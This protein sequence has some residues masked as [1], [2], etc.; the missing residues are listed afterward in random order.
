MNITLDGYLAGP[1]CEL[2]WHFETWAPDMAE[3]LARE[4]SKTDTILLGRITYQA[5]AAY[6]Q[7]RATDLS[8]PREEIAFV[9]M[10]NAHHKIVYSKTL[11]QA[12]WNNSSILQGDLPSAIL[13]LKQS[14]PDK[15][16][17]IYGSSQLV[18][19]LIDLGLIDE[20]HLW[21][22][23]V[24]LGKGKP[25]FKAIRDKFVLRLS[26]SRTFN[27]GVVLLQYDHIGHSTII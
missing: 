13:Q 6:W 22:H 4:L 21:L 1:N 12:D 26:R 24:I 15:D 10:M 9:E 3:T 8:C 20:Y 11:Q 25:L 23:P 7:R 18:A 17:I 27:S 2:D 19:A 16:I 14:G 5:M